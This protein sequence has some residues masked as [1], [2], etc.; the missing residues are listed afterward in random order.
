[1]RHHDLKP[2]YAI[3]VVAG[4]LLTFTGC[5]IGNPI[6]IGLSVILLAASLTLFITND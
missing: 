6:M 3:G 1:M 4:G 2:I 5:V